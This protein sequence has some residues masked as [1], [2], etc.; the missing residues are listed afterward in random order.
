MHV[1][2]RMIQPQYTPVEDESENMEN[3]SFPS[4]NR[5]NIRKIND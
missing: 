2:L 3:N 1:N 4:D 5:I